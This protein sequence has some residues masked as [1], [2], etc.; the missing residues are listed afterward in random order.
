MCACACRPSQLDFSEH[1]GATLL[2][3][4]VWRDAREVSVAAANVCVFVCVCLCVHTR[5]KCV[6]VCARVRSSLFVSLVRLSVSAFHHAAHHRHCRRCPP[7]LLPRKAGK[8]APPPPGAR[9]WSYALAE[10][11]VL[12]LL[13]L[14]CDPSLKDA[15]GY[16]ASD[17]DVF[18][19]HEARHTT[20]DRPVRDD[21]VSHNVSHDDWAV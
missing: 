19:R 3:Y 21:S 7:P 1:V 2:G 11:Y 10:E 16:V 13:A 12:T 9:P 6:C 20:H 18:D 8:G 15:L 14:G 5:S 17:F 4:V